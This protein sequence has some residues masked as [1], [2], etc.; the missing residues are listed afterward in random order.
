MSSCTQVIYDEQCEIC[1]AGVS[2]LKILDR[3]RRVVCHAIDPETLPSIHPDLTVEACLRELHIVTPQGDIVAGADA[4]IMLARLFRPTWWIGTVARV[5]GLHA[6]ARTLYRFVAQNRYAL[7]KCRGGACRVV[8]PHSLRKRSAFGAFWSCYV[9]GMLIRLP[10]SIAAAARDAVVRVARYVYTSRK[11]ID[12]LDRRLRLLFIGGI[13]CDVVPLVFGEQ[14]WTVVYD[15][16]AIDPGSPKMRRSLERHLKKLPAH[17][18]RAVLATHHHEEHVGNLNWLAERTGAE[19]YVSRATAELLTK[20]LKLPWARRFIIGSPPPLQAP[21]HTLEQKLRTKTGSLDVYAAPGHCHDHIVLYDAREKLAIVADAFMGIYFSAPN[22][23]VDSR[24]WIETIESLMGLDIEILIEGHGF[25][26]TMRQD[27]PNVPG[28]VIRR[29]PRE[30]LREKLRY[31]KWLRQQI[32]A[33]FSEGLSICAVEATCF[34]WGQRQA[35]E[36]FINDQLMRFL[37]LGHWSRTELVRSFVRL[38]ERDSILPLV[39]RARIHSFPQED[40]DLN[41]RSTQETQKRTKETL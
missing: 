8:R 32:D 29:D 7:S 40:R 28:V 20:P 36:S 15:G 1:Q 3:H 25:I 39:Y 37:S 13:P 4:V 30:E 9:V 33:G 14:F 22:P 18:I 11:R 26:H 21:Y 19:V 41:T 31:L 38:P 10:L 24:S 23:D 5:P 6:I 27:I 35:W 17:E 12:L 16:I 2:W 34:P